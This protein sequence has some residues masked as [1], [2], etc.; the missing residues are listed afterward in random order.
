[1]KTFWRV[2]SSG[3][4]QTRPTVAYYASRAWRF[5]NRIT[6]LCARERSSSPCFQELQRVNSRSCERLPARILHFLERDAGG[7]A[8]IGRTVGGNDSS[9]FHRS[10]SS[11]NGNISRYRDTTNTLLSM[12]FSASHL[13]VST[14]AR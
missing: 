3:Y 9:G 13:P 12:G 5:S 4:F 14:S 8:S 6:T 2:A 1:M 10:L 7:G 11:P